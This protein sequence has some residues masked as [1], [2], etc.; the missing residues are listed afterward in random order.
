MRH[1]YLSILADDNAAIFVAFL[2]IPYF[3]FSSLISLSIVMITLYILSKTQCLKRKGLS[4]A[5]VVG[6]LHVKCD[7]ASLVYPLRIQ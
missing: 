3:T 4:D 5:G 7:W 2:L 1:S 6:S